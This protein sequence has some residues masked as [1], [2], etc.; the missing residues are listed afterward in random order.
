[1][2]CDIEREREGETKRLR[3]GVREK[4]RKRDT[5]SVTESK[6]ESEREREKGNEKWNRYVERL[7][8]KVE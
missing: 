6:R 1:M 2:V 7:Y 4:H 3:V 5:E 8:G